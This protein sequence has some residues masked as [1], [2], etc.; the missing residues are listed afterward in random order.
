MLSKVKLAGAHAHHKA[1]KA[2]NKAGDAA[3]KFG[4]D[5]KLAEKLT[6]VKNA[7]MTASKKVT[8]KGKK[9]GRKLAKKLK[10]ISGMESGSSPTCYRVIY[11]YSPQLDEQ[12][13]LFITPG[14]NKH[15][16]THS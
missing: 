8:R 15:R 9:V 4:E 10:S 5:H 13:C 1:K 6:N 11:A 14:Q 3:R 2:A 7:T 16:I 12:E